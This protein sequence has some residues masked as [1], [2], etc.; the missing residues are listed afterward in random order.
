MGLLFFLGVHRR[1]YG[2]LS[3]TEE[4]SRLV[5]GGGIRTGTL[6]IVRVLALVFHFVEPRIGSQ[7][8]LV[9][10]DEVGNLRTRLY[11]F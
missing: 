4:L 8:W 1:F 2:I 9:G 6:M 7:C 11:V 10:D 5:S 3:R